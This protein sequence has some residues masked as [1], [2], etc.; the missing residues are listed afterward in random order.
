MPEQQADD[1]SKKD[2]FV[3][4]TECRPT[5]AAGTDEF[6]QPGLVMDYF[7]GNTVTGLWNYA[8][9]YAMSDNN[10]DTAFGPST[11]GALNVISGNTGGGYA[12]DPTT[13]ARRSQTPA[14]VSAL[15][16]KGLGTIYGDIDPSY[17]ECSDNSH[18]SHQ[19][20]GRAD[21]PEHRRPAQRRARHA[22]AG[23]RA[24]SRRPATNSGG[25]VCGAEH[26][27]IGGNDGPRPTTRRTTTRSSTTRRRRT[28]RTCR[29][30]REAAI[31]HTD[32]ANHQYD[33]SDFTD[34]LNGRRTCRR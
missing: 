17:D 12:V 33:M 13:P 34:A 28:R 9:N 1:S 2:T 30:P 26:E 4:N 3:Q 11:P 27:N 21:R 32:Q 8:Q 14:P 31:G 7:D 18:T 20:G 24:A 10:F 25:A 15:N 6:C 19:P 23:S 16:S 29:R 22:G 5:C